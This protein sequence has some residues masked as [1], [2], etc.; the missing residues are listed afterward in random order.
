MVAMR[1]T[2]RTL[3]ADKDGVLER[4]DSELLELKIR[5]S[6]TPTTLRQRINA[7]TSPEGIRG[8]RS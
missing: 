6:Q 7:R 1:L 2:L 8:P 5:E 3:L 4:S